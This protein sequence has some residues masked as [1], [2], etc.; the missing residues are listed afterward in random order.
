M[1]GA[2]RGGAGSP[3]TPPPR[4][5]AAE[6][7]SAL[8]AA[9]GTSREPGAATMDIPPLAGKIAALSFGALPLSYALNYVSAL[10]QCVR[11]GAG[12]APGG[13]GARQRGRVGGGGEGGCAGS[14]P[15]FP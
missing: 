4:S 8:E 14:E 3:A 6:E 2:G 12:A 13:E 5:A 10:S 15:G 7:P 9:P 1:R 11:G